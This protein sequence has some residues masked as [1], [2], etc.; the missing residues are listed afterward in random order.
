MWLEIKSEHLTSLDLVTDCG[1]EQGV[2]LGLFMCPLFCGL[3]RKR[4]CVL[5]SLQALVQTSVYSR[6]YSCDQT[7]SLAS[8]V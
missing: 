3:C 2:G 5:H 4:Q 7:E 6:P 1:P 8:A